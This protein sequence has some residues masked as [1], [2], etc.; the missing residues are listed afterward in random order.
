MVGY[1][2][3]RSPAFRGTV[4]IQQPSRP[5]NV[6]TSSV[7]PHD[8]VDYEFFGRR[9][10]KL[11]IQA[12]KVTSPR[13]TGEGESTRHP[14][15]SSEA[16]TSTSLTNSARPHPASPHDQEEYQRQ[17]RMPQE[18]PQREYRVM[19]PMYRIMQSTRDVEFNARRLRSTRPISI[20]VLDEGGETRAR[21][22]GAM[23]A[24]MLRSLRKPIDVRVTVASLGPP[25]SDQDLSTADLLKKMVKL[26]MK[27]DPEALAIVERVPRQFAEVQDPVENDL[28]LVMDRYDLQETLRE[29]SVLD[30]ISPGQGYSRRIKTIAPFASLQKVGRRV[31]MKLP[32]EILDP[33]YFDKS[34]DFNALS[35]DLALCCKGVVDMLCDV[36]QHV[37]RD[38]AYDN[39][40][41]RDVVQ[42]IL[43]CPGLWM[44]LPWGRRLPNVSSSL[45]SASFEASNKHGPS[46]TLAES[47][48]AGPLASSWM[49]PLA[50][51]YAVRTVHGK[52][53]IAKKN[54]KERGYWRRIENVENELRKWME[55]NQMSSVL[56]TQGMLR[57]SGA[58][59]LAS[60]IDY[61]GGLSVFADLMNLK[62][63]TRR[64]NGYWKNFDV[65]RDE[66]LGFL[67]TSSTVSDLASESESLCSSQMNFVMPTAQELMKE[68]RSDLVRAVRLHGG[69]TQVA[70][71][72]GIH[73]HRSS[74]QWEEVGILKALRRLKSQGKHISRQ[75][76]R[77]EDMAGLE[78]AIDRLGGFP[79]FLKLLDDNRESCQP[80]PKSSSVDDIW[81]SESSSCDTLQCPTP[82]IEKVANSVVVWMETNSD[83]KYRLPTRQELELNGRLDIWRCIQRAGGLQKL[84]E[85]LDIPFIETRGRKKVQTRKEQHD[86]ANETEETED[87][88]QT[89]KAYEDFTLV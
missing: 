75:A 78:S 54:N 4:A 7:R 21:L 59:S 49:L 71:A 27:D 52:R 84:S 83:I 61:H 23:L 1:R 35:K 73:S 25:T 5:D 64:P 26:W 22:T 43:S 39:L 8:G 74:S 20:L 88:L 10:T 30:A 15:Q 31:G 53:V 82:Y 76:I 18:E 6:H 29:V 77:E 19:N 72:M 42:Q 40:N 85:Y 44:E 62:L 89:W 36:H 51:Q 46:P 55:R 65:L 16:S 2:F 45:V 86:E 81:S 67:S 56:P 28:I 68:G 63:H 47:F 58:H 80:F 79:Y 34:E 69:F 60:S 57:S 50:G 11:Q 41:A 24:Y 14:R 12:D 9:L 70:L 33:I 48:P 13:R 3:S 17:E 66:L 87:L 37:I 32:V 38:R